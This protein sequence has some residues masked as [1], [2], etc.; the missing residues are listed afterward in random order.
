MPRRSDS[1]DDRATGTIELSA[2]AAGVAEAVLGAKFRLDEYAAV[3]AD[4]YRASSSLGHLS[5]PAFAIGEVRVVIKFAIAQIEHGAS[6]EKNPNGGLSQ[7]Y[8]HVATTSLADLAPAF[9]SEIELK[10]APEVKRS[11]PSE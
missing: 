5:P 3:V 9:I 2:L 4:Q 6:T 11:Q 10:I 8:V 1:P 7:V